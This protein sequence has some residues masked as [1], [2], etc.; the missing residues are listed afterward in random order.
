M[1]GQRIGLLGGSFNPAHGGHRD[2]SLAALAALNLDAVWWLVSPGNPLKDPAS[3][4]GY[5]ER[6]KQAAHIASHSQIY[7]SDFEK[8]SGTQYTC[9]LYTSPSPRD[10]QKSRMPSSA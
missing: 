1:Q 10:R 7:I 8:K 6:T 3:Y 5:E 9:L 4:A 2:I